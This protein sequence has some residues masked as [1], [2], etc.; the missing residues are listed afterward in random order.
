MN[1]KASNSVCPIK[2]EN[3]PI[4]MLAR[5]KTSVLCCSFRVVDETEIDAERNRNRNDAR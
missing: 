2:T 5:D 4:I 3:G 1:I